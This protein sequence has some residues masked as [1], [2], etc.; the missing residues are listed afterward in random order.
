[1][2]PEVIDYDLPMEGSSTTARLP[3]QEGVRGQAFLCHEFA[4]SMGQMMFTKFVIVVDEDVDC[5]DYSQVAWRCFNNVDPSRD[6]QI[7]KGPL[8]RLDHSSNLQ[9]FGYKMGIDATKPLPRARARVTLSMSP[10]QGSCGRDRNSSGCKLAE[11]TRSC[12]NWSSS[13]LDLLAVCLYQALSVRC[14][15]DSP[16][17]GRSGARRPDTCVNHDAYRIEVPWTLPP[18]DGISG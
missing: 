1:M 3:D 5:H 9:S 11:K 15:L 7:S 17:G 6:I 8:D 2:L 16:V 14:G 4:W 12:S 13:G 18:S 10:S